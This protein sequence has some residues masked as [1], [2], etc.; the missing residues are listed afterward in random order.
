MMDV[1]DK[2][3]RNKGNRVKHVIINNVWKIGIFTYVGKQSGYMKKASEDT[4]LEISFQTKM[5]REVC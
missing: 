1:S 5:Q 4:D 2:V 3:V